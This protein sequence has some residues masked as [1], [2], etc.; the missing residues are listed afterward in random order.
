M[1]ESL[2]ILGV[3]LAVGWMIDRVW[4]LRGKPTKC[5]LTPP[6]PINT[7]PERPPKAD[8]DPIPSPSQ[9]LRKDWLRLGRRS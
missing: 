5:T 8:R 2:I 6:R 3:I 9:T 4:T 1:G 7:E